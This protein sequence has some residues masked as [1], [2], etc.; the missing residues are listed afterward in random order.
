MDQWLWAAR[1]FRTRAL[2]ARACELGRVESNGVRAKP[3]RDV[4]AGDHLRVESES[5]IFA[6]EVLKLNQMRGPSV[7]AQ[8]LYQESESSREARQKAAAERR[9]MQQYAPLPERRPTKRDRRRI[10]RFRGGV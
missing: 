5:G 1:F 4:H 3:A 6:I 2:A 9:A 10:V 8:T 7:V